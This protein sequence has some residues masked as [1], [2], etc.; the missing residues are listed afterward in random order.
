MATLAILNTQLEKHGVYDS[1]W[2]FILSNETGVIGTAAGVTLGIATVALAYV[3]AT[4]FAIP[5]L[6]YTTTV[7][8]KLFNKKWSYRFTQILFGSKLPTFQFAQLWHVFL[9]W[10]LVVVIVFLVLETLRRIA[11]HPKKNEHRI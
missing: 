1:F 7:P 4:A 6:A 2:N 3:M 10:V 8:I 11:R 9:V 5:I